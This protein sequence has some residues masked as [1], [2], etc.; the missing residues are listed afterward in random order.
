MPNT[1]HIQPF[2]VGRD[3]R[4][5]RGFPKAVLTSSFAKAMEDRE[6]RKGNEATGVGSRQIS[7]HALFLPLMGKIQRLFAT[8]CKNGLVDRFLCALV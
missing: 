4:A 3:R 2:E 5:R 6:G 8:F 1:V 7:K